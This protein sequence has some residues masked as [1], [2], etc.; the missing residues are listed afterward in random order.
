VAAWSL[1]DRNG[2]Q[3]IWRR[4]YFSIVPTPAGKVAERFPAISFFK[5]S[6]GRG[7]VY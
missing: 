5:R 6:E 2:R 7:L 4:S 1:H 3:L